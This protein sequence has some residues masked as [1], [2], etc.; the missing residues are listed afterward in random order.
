MNEVNSLA[1]KRLVAVRT[2]KRHDKVH[3]AW[4]DDTNEGFLICY[5]LNLVFEDD[6]IYSVRPC[7]VEIDGRYPSLGLA[8]E[9]K[10]DFTVSIPFDISSLPMNV[11]ETIQ[12]D[13]LGEDVVNQYV[14]VLESGNKIMV[15]HVYPPMTLGIKVEAKNA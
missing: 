4:R 8:L 13:Y 6:V 3:S 1:D 12:S 14:F 9:Q 2:G 10:T 5:D 11:C 15:R 7:E